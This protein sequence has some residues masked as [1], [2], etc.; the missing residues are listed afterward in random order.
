MMVPSRTRLPNR[1]LAET[2]DLAHGGMRIAA[3]IGRS[4]PGARRGLSR[5][6]ASGTRRGGLRL[7]NAIAR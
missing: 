1:R 4:V 3:A 7:R 5:W 2:H 6:R